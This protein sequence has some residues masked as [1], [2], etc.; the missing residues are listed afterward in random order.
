[1]SFPD[2]QRRNKD[3]SCW[4]VLDGDNRNTRQVEI[5]APSCRQSLRRLQGV[6]I[7]ILWTLAT[8][9]VQMHGREATSQSAQPNL[10]WFWGMLLKST[11]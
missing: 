10:M 7:E 1:M 11:E 2:Y 6:E 9:T 4:L 8:E 5:T 3:I